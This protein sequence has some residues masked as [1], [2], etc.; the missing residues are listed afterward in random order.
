[1]LQGLKKVFQ[2]NGS[3]E[4][5]RLANSFNIATLNNYYEG[6][7]PEPIRRGLMCER[8]SENLIK[9]KLTKN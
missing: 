7:V 1:M 2:T 5:Q 8:F 3:K 9:S 4:V 6:Y